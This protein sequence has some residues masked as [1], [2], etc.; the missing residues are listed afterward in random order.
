MIKHKIVITTGDSDGIGLE[1]ALKALKRLTPQKNVQFI[2]WRSKKINS[3]LFSLVDRWNRLTVDSLEDALCTD[4]FNL[5][6]IAS[7]ESPAHWVEASARACLENRVSAMA[8]GPLS[9]ISIKNSGFNDLGHTEILKRVSGANNVNMAFIGKK[10]SVV[11]VTDH[12]PLGK[13]SRALTADKI[14]GAIQNSNRLRT[15]LNNKKR[16]QPMAVLGLNPHAG[17]QGLIGGEETDWTEKII[18]YGKRHKIPLEVSIVPDAA[19]LKSNWLK[20]SL[21]ISLYHDQGLIPFKMIHGQDSGV[22]ITLGIPFIRTSVDHGTAKNIFGKNIA[23]PNSML[24][25][26]RWALKLTRLKSY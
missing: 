24:D 14:I 6:D 10:F 22:H 12:L 23:N 16:S 4:D 13:V 21:Y 9:K 18:D 7:S 25:A 1:V 19:F 20:Y 11:L 26:I 15:L 17:E 2:L 3:K 8:T 5:V